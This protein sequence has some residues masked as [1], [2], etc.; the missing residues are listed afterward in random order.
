M[1]DHQHFNQY[2]CALERTPAP[3][4][5]LSDVA[6]LMLALEDVGLPI[7]DQ[8][9]DCVAIEIERAFDRHGDT[10]A[11][12]TLAQIFARLPG[13]RR[14]TELRMVLTQATCCLTDEAK[15]LG[16]SKQ[17]LSQSV[18]RLQRRLLAKKRLRRRHK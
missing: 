6:M 12:E 11:A 2:D 4:P 16:I 8:K 1:N 5:E 7:P 13:G 15:R 10:R 17:S 18:K 9:R 3:E 14:G